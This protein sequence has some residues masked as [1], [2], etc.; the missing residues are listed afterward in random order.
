MLESHARA[1]VIRNAGCV[2]CA[3]PSPVTG[4][5]TATTD[6]EVFCA[7]Y[8]ECLDIALDQG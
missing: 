1:G 7:H 5:E 2:S 8:G 3:D 4:V 6:R